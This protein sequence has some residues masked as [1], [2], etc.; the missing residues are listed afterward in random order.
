MYNENTEAI[1]IFIDNLHKNGYYVSMDD[2]GSGYSNLASLAKLDFDIIKLDKTFCSDM[3]NKKEQTILSFIMK[4]VKEL[5]IDVLCEGVETKELV[6]NL[7]ELG[8]YL[9]QGYFYSKPIPSED[10]IQKF[11]IK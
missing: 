10:F 7:K 5:R 4:L 9:V 11:L 2:F 1:S 6:E 3:T 8:C